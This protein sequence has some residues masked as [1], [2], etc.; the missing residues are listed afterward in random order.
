MQRRRRVPLH[1]RGGGAAR[2]RDPRLRDDLLGLGRGDDLRLRARRRRR[3][4]RRARGGGDRAPPRRCDE[5]FA[6]YDCSERLCPRGD[7]P[8]TAGVDE[9]QLVASR[10]RAGFR[11][12]EN[13]EPGPRD[14]RARRPVGA[15]ATS[16]AA[17]PRPAAALEG[18][19]LAAEARPSQGR[20]RERDRGADVPRPTDGRVPRGRDGGALGVPPRTAQHRRRRR[21]RLRRRRPRRVPLQRRRHDRPRHLPDGTR[22]RPGAQRDARGPRPLEAGP[23]RRAAPRSSAPRRAGGTSTGRPTARAAAST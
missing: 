8:L 1:G 9:V 16:R 7:D 14:A 4:G 13:E 23:A 12:F 6:G 17:R 10:A 11:D 3:V 22:R 15:T 2:L 5:G 21:R 20:L 19:A 18:P